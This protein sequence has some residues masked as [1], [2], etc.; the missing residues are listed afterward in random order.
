MDLS[1][2]IL[3]KL[4]ELQQQVAEQSLL[5]KPVLNFKETCKYLG[6]SE[7]HLYKLTS[8]KE[9]PHYCPKGKR[10]YFNR[11]E[12]DQWLQQNRQK[13]QEEIDREATNYLIQHGRRR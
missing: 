13:S 12:L 6:L 5:S 11:E 8:R 9:I 1:D 2:Q 4:E 7:S 3:E 10:L